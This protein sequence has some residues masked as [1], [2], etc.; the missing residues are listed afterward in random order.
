[1]PSKSQIA[2]ALI[3]GMISAARCERIGH[4]NGDPRV[5]VDL[6]KKASPIVLVKHAGKAPRLL[7]EWLHILDLH[8]EDISRLGAFHL[9]RARQVV[10]L[11]EVDVL[12]I[13][14]TV[15][16][17]N[18]ASCPIDTLHLEDLPISNFGRE[19]NCRKGQWRL[20]RI[21]EGSSCRLD[22]IYSEEDQRMLNECLD[23]STNMKDGLLIRWFL[24]VDLDGG[25]YLREPHV[26]EGTTSM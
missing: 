2:L 10:N 21:V 11:G 12:H 24:Q 13:V 5:R 1:M 16:V 17:A 9:E 25:S 6:V 19:G 8:H 4:A 26:G 7:L 15:I 14:R 3:S 20:G 18:L 23:G 22:A